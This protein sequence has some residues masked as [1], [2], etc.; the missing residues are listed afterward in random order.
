M[1]EPASIK[2]MCIMPF[3]LYH[4]HKWMYAELIDYDVGEKYAGEFAAAT[5]RSIMNLRYMQFAS[6]LFTP[7]GII[8]EQVSTFRETSPRHLVLR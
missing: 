5:A 7:S 6:T 4:N 1:N 3:L 2:Q 8:L